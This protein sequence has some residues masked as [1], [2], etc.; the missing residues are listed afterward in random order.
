VARLA[1]SRD[2]DVLGDDVIRAVFS[3][4]P[5]FRI[6]AIHDQL[7]PTVIFPFDDDSKTRDACDC[8]PT[9]TAF[10]CCTARRH[11][12]SGSAT[13]DFREYDVGVSELP[14]MLSAQGKER[15]TVGFEHYLQEAVSDANVEKQELEDALDDEIDVLE[16]LN[17]FR[18]QP[19]KLGLRRFNLDIIGE[20]L[21][22]LVEFHEE[23]QTS[24]GKINILKKQSPS[25]LYTFLF[26]QIL[27]PP[28]FSSSLE[29][30]TGLEVQIKCLVDVL[31]LDSLWF[32]FSL[33]EWRLRVGQILWGNLDDATTE[34]DDDDVMVSDREILILQITLSCELLLR[35]DAVSGREPVRNLDFS[36]EALNSFRKLQTRKTRWDLILAR[37]FLRNVD[38]QVA[39]HEASTAPNRPSTFFNLGRST[40]T[41]DGDNVPKPSVSFRPQHLERQLAT[42]FRFARAV[43][44]P[45]AAAVEAGLRA[46]LARCDNNP[47][48]LSVSAA[49]TPSVY[50]TP[51]TTCA[52]PLAH[53]RSAS[54]YFDARLALARNPTATSAS[55]RGLLSAPTA[56]AAA[57]AGAA[58]GWLSRAYLAGLLLPGAAAPRLLMATLLAN[59]AAGLAALGGGGG[60]GGGEEPGAGARNLHGALTRGGR[61]WWSAACTAVARVAAPMEGAAEEALWVGLPVAVE[62]EGDGWVD[63]APAVEPARG[64]KGGRG[65][66]IERGWEVE[67]DGAVVPPGGKARR[68]DFVVPRE[69][70]RSA[71]TGGAVRLEALVLVSSPADA[72]GGFSET[73]TPSRT[74]ALRFSRDGGAPVV[75]PLTFLVSFVSAFPCFPP[76]PATLPPSWRADGAPASSP[77]GHPLLRSVRHRAVEAADLLP[78]AT[79]P[80]V[81]V[82]AAAAEEGEVL[83]IDARGDAA[84]DVLARAW[85]ASGG[86]DAVVGRA[87]VTCLACCVREA[88]AAEIGVVIRV[89]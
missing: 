53:G 47:D 52:H 42:L 17:L 73:A 65:P 86:L 33:P 22:E 89:R 67:A 45:D 85:C 1:A 41:P 78:S 82:A 39:R 75:L 58:T 76:P 9:D 62:G 59:D 31:K 16:N 81:G 13:E 12:A 50:S 6:Q 83:V 74:A 63:V 19:E 69:E 34:A 46:K 2:G 27:M 55:G 30:Q 4:A 32:D 38:V 28:K 51:L 57:V 18:A 79:G 21:E 60:G 64:E 72:R 15:G 87:G 54:G 35:L 7:L 56:A 40:F 80:G 68:A 44:W 3:G 48:D 36:D 24:S 5:Q 49:T 26:S 23:F 43:S 84:L 66:R 77:S 25:E 20:R 29:D 88:R 8:R 37:T 61:T 70:D 14:C 11:L 10:S 71:Q